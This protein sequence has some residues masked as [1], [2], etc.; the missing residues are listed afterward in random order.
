MMK[1]AVESVL[2][3]IYQEVKEQS[4][5][6]AVNHVTPKVI[7]KPVQSTPKLNRMPELS[8]TKP[9]EVESKPSLISLKMNEWGI[10][11]LTILGIDKVQNSYENAVK[12]AIYSFTNPDEKALSTIYLILQKSTIWREAI[13]NNNL[14]SLIVTEEQKKD[15]ETLISSFAQINKTCEGQIYKDAF[16]RYSIE[17]F[18][19]NGKDYSLCKK[20]NENQ[21]E[22]IRLYR[23]KVQLS[24]SQPFYHY[25]VLYPTSASTIS[26]KS[27]ST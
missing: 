3:N 6:E 2:S 21:K 26:K 22:T 24:G 17:I 11:P 15:M 10:F 18:E 7:Q 12:M 16:R 1:N 20:I 9:V 13:R 14:K 25:D 23:K 19:F 27:G 5:Q 4:L 8:I